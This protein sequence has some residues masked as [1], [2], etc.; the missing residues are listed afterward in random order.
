MGAAAPAA[1]YAG[2]TA[3]VEE[4]SFEPGETTLTMRVVGRVR[5]K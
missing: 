2:G 5:F 4:P 1:M 3:Q